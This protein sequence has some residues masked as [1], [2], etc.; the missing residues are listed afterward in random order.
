[1]GS[2]IVYIV[3]ITDDNLGHSEIHSVYSTQEAADDMKQQLESRLGEEMVVYV[4]Q[5]EVLDS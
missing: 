1:M 2:N 5:H 3:L 4:E